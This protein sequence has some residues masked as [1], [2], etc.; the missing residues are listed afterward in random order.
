ML[1]LD[2]RPAP[3][4]AFRVE[5]R[6]DVRIP[7][8]DGLELSAT[9]WLPVAEVGPAHPEDRFPAILEMI[10]YRKDDWRWASDEA[11]GQ[12]LAARGYAFCRLDVRGTGS[13]PGVALGEYTLEETRDGYDTVEWLAAQP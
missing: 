6:R 9:L 3:L 11:R 12:W 1:P 5:A 8:Q 10:P 2:A 4:P 13:S 7:V